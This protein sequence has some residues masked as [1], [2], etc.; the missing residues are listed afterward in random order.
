MKIHQPVFTDDSEQFHTSL[1]N[2]LAVLT[3]WSLEFQ[4][5]E[6]ESM[7]ENLTSKQSADDPE[8]LEQYNEERVTESSLETEGTSISSAMIIF[9]V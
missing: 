7:R 5:D 4:D 2:V 6:Q 9:M 8:N 1:Q 3:F